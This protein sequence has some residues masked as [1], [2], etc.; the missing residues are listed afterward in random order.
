VGPHVRSGTWYA[1]ATILVV[2]SGCRGRESRPP[3]DPG[4]ASAA[5]HAAK[6]AAATES[7]HE[8]ELAKLIAF[9]EQ[10]RSATDFATQPTSDAML[11]PDPYRIVAL[12]EHRIGLLHN[13]ST[14]VVLDR[15]GTELA[16]EAAPRSPSGLVVSAAGDI[17]VVGEA[18]RAIWQLR[19]DDGALRRIAVLPV[20]ARGMRDIALSPDGK[21]VYVVEEWTGRLLA[22][23][24]EHGRD[25]TL[26]ATATR[27]LSRCHGPVHVQVVDGY[28]ATDCLLDHALEIRPEGKSPIRI[29]HDGPIWSF[30]IERTTDG[31]A[32]IAAGGVEDHPLV[33]EDGGFGYID[34]Y[35]YLYRL[36]PGANEPAKLATINT[37]E[38][39]AVTP[40]W[41]ALRAGADAV[42]AR[43]AGYATPNLI[44]VSWRDGRFDKPTITRSDLVPGTAAAVIADDGT[45]IAADPLLDAWVTRDHDRVNL[46]R[47][48]E[49][50]DHPARSLESRIGELLFYTTMMAPWNS[51]E[52]KLSRFTCETCHHEGYVDGRTHFTGRG[53][54][55]ATT[56]TLYGLFN[57]RP[58]FS[59]ALDKTMAEM[60][61]AEFRVANRHNGRDPWF[62]LSHAD[63]PWLDRVEG[64][65]P[66]L[67]PTLLRKSFMQFL[68]DNTH[69][70][71]PA[72]IDRPTPAHFTPLERTGARVFR[73]RCATCHAA[74]L[75]AEDPKSEVP[76]ERWESLVLSNTGPIV[77][78]NA[79]YGK[80]GVTPYVHD[81]GTRA[82]ALRRL[83]KK[84]P[85]FTNGSAKSLADVLD[86]YAYAS[87]PP[88][89]GTKQVFH[90]AA[91]TAGMTRL[92]PADKTALAAF[93]DLL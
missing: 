43:L 93:L 57:N 38:L 2:A 35:L 1:A 39:G 52:G 53:K 26:R 68:I 45:L 32:L 27:E 54:V 36:A 51:S 92:T 58:H 19:Y 3:D 63:L 31:G 8:R 73:D 24:L 48:A 87:E 46:V 15:A 90:D 75:I 47:V 28:V 83:Y 10:T 41:I 40:K 84:W 5:S 72:A 64:I 76:F 33:R 29:H 71:N 70:P 12:G 37:S 6:V 78:S 67:S 69:R 55:H 62:S 13:S 49:S 60:V 21:T 18:E 79:D 91:P 9:E 59:R 77:W 86:R 30:A 11:G 61:H 16:R 7:S 66:T 14:I 22:V 65:P 56:R 81:R 80:T 34:S 25:H 82:P 17:L 74:R 4:G 88:G 50:P 23:A 44:E 20:D 89:R 85:Y 42:T